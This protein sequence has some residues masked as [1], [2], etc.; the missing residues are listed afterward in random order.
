MGTMAGARA[1]GLQD[2]IGSV[3]PGKR[4]DLVMLRCDDLA[5][6][7]L[8]NLG[9]TVV[10]AADRRSVELVM[11]DGAI[12]KWRGSIVA[13]DMPAMRESIRRTRERLQVAAGRAMR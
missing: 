12:M 6:M 1:L 13:H 7:P 8:N 5:T 9:A 4:A 10:L 2:R 3:T 11:V